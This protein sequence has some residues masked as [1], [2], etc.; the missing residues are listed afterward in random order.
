MKKEDE[1]TRRQEKRKRG[2]GRAQEEQEIG[3][4]QPFFFASFILWAIAC[5]VETE[6]KHSARLGCTPSI[7]VLFPSEQ[8]AWL[9]ALVHLLLRFIHCVR[10]G[11][12]FRKG[13]TDRL[14]S[15]EKGGKRKKEEEAKREGMRKRERKMNR[16]YKPFSSLHSL[17]SQWP[18]FS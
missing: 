3:K 2:E 4:D 12:H 17:C 16:Q 15:E 1:E 10:N 6:M 13:L 7:V 14:N 9:C 11:L 5:L 18:A 8:Y